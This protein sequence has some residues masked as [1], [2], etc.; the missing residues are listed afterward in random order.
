MNAKEFNREYAV[1]S[2]FIYLT[3]TAETGGKVV[4]TKD[5]ARD[6]EKSGAVVEI[7]LAPFFVKLSSLKPAD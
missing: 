1:G 7:S 6:L 2:R 4:R 5:V 3:G